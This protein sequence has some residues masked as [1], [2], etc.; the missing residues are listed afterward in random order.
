MKPKGIHQSY[1]IARERYAAL[2]ID[3]ENALLQMGDFHLSINS[4]PV[5]CKTSKGSHLREIEQLRQDFQSAVR[6]VPG[7][8][9]LMLSTSFA[10]KDGKRV[11]TEALEASDFESW[12]QW[13]RSMHTPLDLHVT[14]QNSN[15]KLTLT[16][17]DPSVRERWK[18]CIGRCREIANIM[19]ENQKAICMMNLSIKDQLEDP[20]FNRILHRQMLEENLNKV[21]SPKK[22]WMRDSVASLPPALDTT[23]VVTYNELIS[24]AAK[25]QRMITISTAD[26]G[27]LLPNVIVDDIS[28]LLLSLPGLLL[29]LSR[30]MQWVSK[31]PSIMDSIVESVFLEILH[32]GVMHRI[33][34]LLDYRYPSISRSNSYVMGVRAAQRCMMRAL[35]EPIHMIQYYEL[36]GLQ[37]E[38]TALLEE[39]RSLPWEAVYDEYCV[40]NNV[41]VGAEILGVLK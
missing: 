26:P 14:I 1:E 19:G 15:D 23:P 25:Y 8:H 13:S 28:A 18:E 36:N 16:S 9:R 38:K 5:E 22:V 10:A 2:G 27:H 4:W 41:P 33:H 39:I 24:Y 11:D 34:Y 32:S 7:E 31:L 12:M 17:T 37:T 6:L 21:L 30:P 40:R 29:Q 3:T 20:A 35:L